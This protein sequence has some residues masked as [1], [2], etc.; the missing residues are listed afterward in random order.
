LVGFKRDGVAADLAA[1]LA[2]RAAGG[3]VEK[4]RRASIDYRICS[5]SRW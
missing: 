3:R 2:L 4:R 1:D 5:A